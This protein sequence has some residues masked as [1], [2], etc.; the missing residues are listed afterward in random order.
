MFGLPATTYTGTITFASSDPLAILPD[1]YTFT[2]SDSGF[3]IFENLAFHTL[4]GQ[5][6]TLTDSDNI[7]LNITIA[8][9]VNPVALELHLSGVP[10]QT[11]AGTP[12][13]LTSTIR[14]EFGLPATTY[15]GT[16]TFA[17]SDPL[18]TLPLSY[19]FTG[20]G[21]DNGSHI[22]EKLILNTVGSQSI[23]L[24][25]V[26]DP[27]LQATLATTVE[28]APP[29][30]VEVNFGATPLTGLVPLVVTFINLSTNAITSTWNF[31][32]SD[33]TFI[34][35]HLSFT[36]TYT[37]TGIYTVT[38]SAGNGILTDTLVRPGYITVTQPV[39]AD[40][41]AFPL[42]GSPP[43]LVLFFNNSSGASEYLWDFGDGLTSTLPSPTHTYAQG[44]V[45]S[46][47]LTATG[48]GG[49]DSQVRSNYVTVTG[50]GQVVLQP[51]GGTGIDT[52]I[53]QSYP[54]NSYGNEITCKIGTRAP[55]AYPGGPYKC[56]LNF[57][58]AVVP[59]GALL[60]HT[61]F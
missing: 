30:T 50:A 57:D 31:G 41:S 55:S 22:F 15:T 38:L 44:G 34:I 9:T 5:T 8:T 45:Y 59:P 60:L 35:P 23:T 11:I 10:T 20:G 32:D 18:A 13:S 19:T 4:G 29:T 37:Q 52:Y 47:I 6:I 43:L 14:N 16:L 61:S 36:H 40:F 1:V 49:Q 58:L 7:G 25:A 24:T 21:G 26:E 56:L 27:G 12:F 42:T 48:R 54:V 28:A 3:H 33:S 2:S 53:D 39:Q 17:A 46:V 51:G